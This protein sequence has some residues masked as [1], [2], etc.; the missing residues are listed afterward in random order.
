MPFI[1]VYLI[2]QTKNNLEGQYKYKFKNNIT[3]GS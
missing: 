2:I 1:L 3:K